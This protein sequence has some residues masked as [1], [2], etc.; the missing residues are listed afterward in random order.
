M[1]LLTFNILN[2]ARANQAKFASG[3]KFFYIKNCSIY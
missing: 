2:N 3:A 1:K